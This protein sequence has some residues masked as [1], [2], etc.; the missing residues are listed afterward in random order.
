MLIRFVVSNYLSFKEETEINMLASAVKSHPHHVYDSGK[1]QL[2]KAGAIYG[3]NA[4]GK[5]NL[6]KA[7]DALNA[8]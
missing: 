8:P 2:V 1:V 5:S 6:I 4:S 3:A 7:I